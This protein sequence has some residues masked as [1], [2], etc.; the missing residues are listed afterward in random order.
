MVDPALWKAAL[1]KRDAPPDL[2]FRPSKR[3]AKSGAEGVTE[4]GKCPGRWNVRSP[5][6]AEGGQAHIYTCD[7]YEEAAVVYAQAADNAEAYQWR[8][9][10]QSN[11]RTTIP[12]EARLGPC[13]GQRVS[14]GSAFACGRA[15]VGR[16]GGI[17]VDGGVAA[18]ECMRA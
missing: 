7:T 10:A 1:I 15:V 11:K 17:G 12:R 8:L 9:M 6:S 5:R 18:F 4:S 14:G 2:K 3:S 16:G 13:S